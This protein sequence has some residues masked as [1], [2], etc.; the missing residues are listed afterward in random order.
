M[1]TI[2]WDGYT[3]AADTICAF[4]GYSAR[5]P[6]NKLKQKGDT[7]YGITGYIA[8]FD[9]WIAWFNAGADPCSPP[10]INT[11]EPDHAGNFLVF[12]PGPAWVYSLMLPY[13]TRVYGPDAWG[14]GN[15][16]AIGAM[17]AGASAVEAVKIAAK[18]NRNTCIANGLLMFDTGGDDHPV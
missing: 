16:F 12:P 18:C 11:S 4:G 5:S 10:P 6:D 15:E 3:V 13:P 2:A 14:S 17:H 1:T 9:A 8:W 7:I